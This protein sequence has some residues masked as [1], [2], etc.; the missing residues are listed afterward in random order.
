MNRNLIVI[1][2]PTAVG[3][4]RFAVKLAR[5]LDTEIISG[6]SMLVYRGFDIGTAKPVL[7]E[8]EG[9]PHHLI[10]VLEPEEQFSAAEFQRMAEEAIHTV[11][12]KGKIPIL[13]GGT[14]LYVKAL[15]EG[16]SFCDTSASHEYRK[17]LET[18][19]ETQGA[20]CLYTMLLQK[21]PVAAGRIHP[22]NV[23]RVIRALEVLEI[24]KEHISDKNFFEETGNLRYQTWVIGLMRDRKNLYER[25]D[26]RVCQMF[27]QG[28]EHE[29]KELLARGIS[30]ECP[31]MQGIGYKETAA[32]LDG[33]CT[34][35]DAIQSI[36]TTT[37]HFAKRQLTWYRRMPY[38]HWY[39]L[40][41][42]SEETLLDR[43]VSDME[44]YFGSRKGREPYFHGKQD[45]EPAG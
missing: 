22:R 19:A 26:M 9:V 4:T 25:I 32:W 20:D 3:K 38:I 13:A 42:A 8:R 18:L 16:Y 34:I 2:G 39:D 11:Q 41:S 33:E 21:D 10:D 35:E 1:L 28:L 7:S 44:T 23:R 17:K 6:D 36:Q 15:L 30:R 37:R 40:E 24:G 31:A 14:A 45:I 5:R 12:A 29:V 43:A 27:E